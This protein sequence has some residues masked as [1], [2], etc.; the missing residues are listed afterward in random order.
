MGLFSKFKAVN[1][2]DVFRAVL[3]ACIVLNACGAYYFL[4]KRTLTIAFNTLDP[5][6]ENPDFQKAINVLANNLP[7][8]YGTKIDIWDEEQLKKLPEKI[9]ET[10]GYVSMSH[11]EW[12]RY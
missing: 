2:E 1:D 5:L 8:A 6:N 9:H 11:K 4:H 3:L 7:K 12:C 10:T